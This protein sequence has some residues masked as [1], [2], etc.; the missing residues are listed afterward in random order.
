M[1][2]AR[3]CTI[4][5]CFQEHH[6]LAGALGRN[7]HPVYEAADMSSCSHGKQFQPHSVQQLQVSPIVI[8]DTPVPE[9]GL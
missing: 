8:L 2:S 1:T 5:A 3:A 6:T 4:E 9:Q 7:E